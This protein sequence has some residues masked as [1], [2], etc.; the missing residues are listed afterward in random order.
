M[1]SALPRQM[2]M[3]KSARCVS[4]ETDPMARFN[5]ASIRFSISGVKFDL[6]SFGF[7]SSGIKTLWKKPTQSTGPSQTDASWDGGVCAGGVEA[8]GLA[9]IPPKFVH[10]QE[11]IKC[12]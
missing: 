5:L 3:Y 10:L 1:R 9:G 12:F 4:E 11:H 8:G 7:N 6:A 2:N